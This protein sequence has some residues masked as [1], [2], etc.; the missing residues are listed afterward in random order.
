MAV[1]NLEWHITFIS[2]FGPFLPGQGCHVTVQSFIS[3]G[4]DPFAVTKDIC[5]YN[6]LSVH[7]L[8]DM[9]G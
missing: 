6:F 2:G 4:D 5:K 1:D 7:I 3:C 8:K 9:A